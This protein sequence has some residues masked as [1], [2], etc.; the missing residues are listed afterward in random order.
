MHWTPAEAAAIRAEGVRV[1]QLI[2]SAAYPYDGTWCDVR[3]PRSWPLPA[4]PQLP[5]GSP[6]A[7]DRP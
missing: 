4:R 3:P 2:D 7:G 1:T 6:A 5:L